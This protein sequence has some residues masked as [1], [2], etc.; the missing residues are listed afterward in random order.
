MYF[1]W[2]N[3]K[4]KRA[5]CVIFGMG[6]RAIATGPINNVWPKRCL[7]LEELEETIECILGSK[8]ITTSSHIRRKE[9]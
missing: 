8:S 6:L 1:D 5:F 4:I 3:L 9:T 7:D 2:I